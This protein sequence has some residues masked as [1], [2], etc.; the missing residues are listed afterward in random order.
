[1]NATIVMVVQI[2]RTANVCKVSHFWVIL[3]NRK[4]WVKGIIVLY[5][6]HSLS[7]IHIVVF[8]IEPIEVS[9]PGK[10]RY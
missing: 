5:C 4:S 3:P 10:G 7:L 9:D 8:L 1:M 2:F 6:D